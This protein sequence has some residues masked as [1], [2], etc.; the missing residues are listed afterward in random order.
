[1]ILLGSFSTVHCL[2]ATSKEPEVTNDK[3]I[4]NK[5]IELYEAG[6]WQQIYDLLL[7][8]RD[9]SNPEILWRLARAARDVSQLPD[10][11]K[12]NKKKLVYE[13]LEY[14]KKAVEHGPDN[15]ACQ[16]VVCAFNKIL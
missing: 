7:R 4:V 1:M 16:K 6:E 11:T 13:C 5:A 9:T 12:D 15:Y 3:A 10:T 8:H 14:A 2:S